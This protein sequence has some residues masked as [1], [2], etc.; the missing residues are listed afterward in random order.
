MAVR[1]SSLKL[2]PPLSSSAGVE[3]GGDG[4]HF[5]AA[6]PAFS[7]RDHAARA[8]DGGKHSVRTVVANYIMRIQSCTRIINLETETRVNLLISNMGH[9]D[10]RQIKLETGGRFRR[11]EQG[12]PDN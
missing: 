2:R 3:S 11:S 5:G 1:Q 6:W 10:S 7:S 8:I 4:G 9:S 12:R